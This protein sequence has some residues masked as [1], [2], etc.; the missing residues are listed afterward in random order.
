MNLIR[1][2]LGSIASLLPMPRD[3]DDAPPVF[4][5]RVDPDAL[6]TFGRAE[7]SQFGVGQGHAGAAPL[8]T[9]YATDR[10]ADAREAERRRTDE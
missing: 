4:D 8:P 5:P 1:W 7:L 9:R 6:E 2:A 3:L 10:A